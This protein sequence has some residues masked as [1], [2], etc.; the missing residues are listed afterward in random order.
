LNADL[1]ATTEGVVLAAMAPHPSGRPP[2]VEVFWRLLS[3]PDAPGR[4]GVEEAAPAGGW[5][6]VWR[7]NAW[8][9][10]LC[11]AVTALVV[12]LTFR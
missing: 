9:I 1:S 10:G 8:L 12:V 3:A 5:R 7:A 2:T 6:P 11:V 4:G